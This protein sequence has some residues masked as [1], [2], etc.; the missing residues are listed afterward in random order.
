MYI[1]HNAL[2]KKSTEPISTQIGHD[3]FYEVLDSM[4][5]E[6]MVLKSF[7]M[8][9]LYASNLNIDIVR[10]VQCDQY[11]HKIIK[12]GLHWQIYATFSLT[13]T[14]LTHKISMYTTLKIN[15]I[16]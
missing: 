2:S 15:V 14:L 4:K 3:I 10:T 1:D 6:F 5:A 12:R 11:Y 7:V 8:Y 16:L 13:P 9:E